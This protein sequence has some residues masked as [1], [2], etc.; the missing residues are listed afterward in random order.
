[1]IGGGSDSGPAPIEDVR[2]DHRSADITVAENLLDGAGRGP[3]RER[4][5]RAWLAHG[6]QWESRRVEATGGS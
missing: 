5:G 3:G 6:P 1:M 2:A 4:N